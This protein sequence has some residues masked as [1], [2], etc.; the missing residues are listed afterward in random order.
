MALNTLQLEQFEQYG[1][2]LFPAL[3]NA[4]EVVVLKTELQRC[5]IAT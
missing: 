5:F 4:A 3:I 1:F 2:L